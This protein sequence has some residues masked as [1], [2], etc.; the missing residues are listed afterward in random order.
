MAFHWHDGL[1]FERLV[2]GTVRIFRQM[3]E[4]AATEIALIPADEWPSI[5]ASVAA[6]SG[7]LAETFRAAKLVHAGEPWGSTPNV[8][9]TSGVTS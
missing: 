5:V 9:V 2:D 7:D 1:H 8:P 3:P 6:S 4:Q